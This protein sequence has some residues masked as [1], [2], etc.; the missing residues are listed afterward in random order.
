M[1]L[2]FAAPIAAL[3]LASP[4]AARDYYYF[5]KPGVERQ[6]YLEDRLTCDALAGGV[7][8]ISP[9]T[10]AMNQQI[11]NNSKLTMGQSAAAA[12]IATVLIALLDGGANRRLQWQVERICL[13]DKGYRRFEM[14][15]TEWK[16]IDRIDDIAERI[17]KWF[18]LA[19]SDAPKGK[20]MYE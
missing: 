19:S 6:A 17:D 2:L 1:K 11:W 3:I 16:A 5:N 10:T 13:A 8:R 9:D 20:E 12:G 14:D 7:A 18:A 15:R 4:V